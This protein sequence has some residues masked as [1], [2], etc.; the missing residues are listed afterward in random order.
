MDSD[1]QDASSS[2]GRL[3]ELEQRL[4]SQRSELKNA[5]DLLKNTAPSTEIEEQRQIID[6]LRKSLEAAELDINLLREEA[7][8]RET[9]LQ[10]AE[11]KVTRL[12]S[13][14]SMIT[15]ELTEFEEDLNVQRRE[16]HRFGIELQKLKVQ[17]QGCAAKHAGELAEVE[18]EFKLSQTKL[19]ATEREL[20][21][22]QRI[23]QKLE[24]QRGLHST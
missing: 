24:Q 4:S 18:R 16:S 5:Q 21:T 3:R 9:T 1:S 12:Q 20:E 14:R 15:K 7:Q 13:E 6:S 23:R 8:T 2:S 22:A 17:Q 11:A 10:T 19:H